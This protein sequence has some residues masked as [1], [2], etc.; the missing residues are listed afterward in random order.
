[1]T[2]LTP[3]AFPEAN[4]VLGKGQEQYQPL[5]VYRAKDGLTVSCWRLTF[6]Q[7]V[8]LLVTGRVWVMQLTFN[9]MFQPQLLQ[10]DSPFAGEAVAE[11]QG[12]K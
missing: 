6:W 10:A 5:P 9:Q 4:A 12:A 1:M 11:P 8:K 7:R 3:V 2:T